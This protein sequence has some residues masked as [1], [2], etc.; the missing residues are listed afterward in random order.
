[1]ATFQTLLDQ[2]RLTLQDADKT[3]YPDAEMVVYANEAMR[4][5]R[6]LRSDLFFATITTPLVDYLVGDTFPLSPEFEYPLKRYVIAAAQA[7][8]DEYAVD[9]RMSKFL[10]QFEKDLTA[11]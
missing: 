5:Y 2:A 9:G 3:R 4:I 10:A 6:K 8:D 7:R 1:M 11:Q